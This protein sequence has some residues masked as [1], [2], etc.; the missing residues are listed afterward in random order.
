MSGPETIEELNAYM[1]RDKLTPEQR[2][3]V[4]NLFRK[5]QAQASAADRNMQV[6]AAASRKS[7]AQQNFAG[8]LAGRAAAGVAGA[9]NAATL[10]RDQQLMDALGNPQYGIESDANKQLYPGSY[11]V[12]Q[13]VGGFVGPVSRVLGGVAGGAASML[14]STGL[15]AQPFLNR[16]AALTAQNLVGGAAASTAVRMGEFNRGDEGANVQGRLARVANDITNPLGVGLAVAGGAMGANFM[17][18]APKDAASKSVDILIQKYEAMNGRKV[19][20]SMRANS[21]SLYEMMD[22]IAQDPRLKDDVAKVRD[23]TTRGLQNMIRDMG[24]RQGGLSKELSEGRASSAVSRQ[25]GSRGVDGLPTQLRRG[26][27]SK[28]MGRENV[29]GSTLDPASAHYAA[30][31]LDSIIRGRSRDDVVGDG[32]VALSK[33][34]Q[35][36]LRET[37]DRTESVVEQIPGMYGKTAVTRTRNVPGTPISVDDLEGLRKQIAEIGFPDAGV[38]APKV[39]AR[40]R[41][42]AKSFYHVLTR[43][44]ESSFPTYAQSMRAGEK[45]RRVEELYQDVGVSDVPAETIGAF[46][47][48]PDILKRFED[49]KQRF[50]PEDVSALK[51]WLAWDVIEK[52]STADGLLSQAKLLQ[53]LRLNGRTNR[54]VVSRILPGFIEEIQTMAQLDARAK[55]GP[56]APVGSRTATRGISE[57][58]TVARPAAAAGVVATWISNPF[59]GA[60]TLL[61]TT[62]VGW[63][64]K[65]ARKSLIDGT[66]GE[67]AASM[68]TGG[69]P[70]AMTR[71]PTAVSSAGGFPELANTVGRAIGDVATTL[72]QG[73][74]QSITPQNRSDEGSAR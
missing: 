5:R 4:S 32:W 39:A 29:S 53:T 63:L 67:L 31:A 25:V 66:M 42:E 8:G 1:E 14:G 40:A 10:G 24:K 17:K 9:T 54:S 47:H 28:A 68:A 33:T 48:G 13:L 74:M 2:V 62:G 70:P 55:R 36:R 56:L 19:P 11:G 46:F 20:A 64:T 50:L 21:A 57:I 43:A 45:L 15:A 34:L 69:M 6:S 23:E 3:E 30:N 58:A 51:G 35:K 65:H 12:G 59:A 38:F 22:V 16:A 72:P 7:S 49:A 37:S 52:S 61:G 18:P 44:S 60:A 73:V 26:A 41:I 27:E 71:I